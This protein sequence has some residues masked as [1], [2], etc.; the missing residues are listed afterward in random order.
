MPG[1]QF[2]LVENRSEAAIDLGCWSLRL[3]A[4]EPATVIPPSFSVPPGATARLFATLPNSGRIELV[5]RDGW[6]I[7][8]TPELSDTAHDDRIWFRT[9]GGWR[10]GR[11][12]EPLREVVDATLLS[13]T[14]TAC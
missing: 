1:G 13:R 2:V 7:D 8:D 10:F 4:M 12:G 5:D 9:P 14:S 6:V 3:D 11:S